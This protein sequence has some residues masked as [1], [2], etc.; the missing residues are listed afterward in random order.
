MRLNYDTFTVFF[1]NIKRP[2]SFNDIPFHIYQYQVYLIIPPLA[3]KFCE[4]V[5]KNIYIFCHNSNEERE[6][7]FYKIP[8]RQQVSETHIHYKVHVTYF[9]FCFI[10]TFII[11]FSS[12]QYKH[13]YMCFLHK[14]EFSLVWCN[15]KNFLLN[16]Y[17]V[18]LYSFF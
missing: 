2:M 12:V 18:I 5:Y 11:I 7:E 17:Y 16:K 15:M 14:K 13:E 4:K 6:K 1:Q 9:F 10:K 3:L 8:G